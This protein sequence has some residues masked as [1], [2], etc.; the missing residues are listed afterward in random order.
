MEE[1]LFAYGTLRRG[2]A[3]AALAERVRDLDWEGEASLAGR[4]YDLGPYPG[5]VL[6]PR[7]TTRIHGEI[8]RVPRDPGFWAL[9]DTYEGTD[10]A[11]P[12]FRRVRAVARCRDGAPAAVWV[13]E[14]ARDPRSARLL[15]DGRSRRPP[16]PSRRR[17]A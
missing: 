15:A 10:G 11:A 12:L 16:T 6:D 7:A 17:T 9:L 5:A 13:Y 8:A 1:R 3:P 2:H 4:L 14:Y